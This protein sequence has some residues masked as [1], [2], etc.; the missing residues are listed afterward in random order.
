MTP[1]LS[2]REQAKLDAAEDKRLN[3]LRE[4]EIM[5]YKLGSKLTDVVPRMPKRTNR[6]RAPPKSDLEMGELTRSR[7]KNHYEDPK[8]AHV[9][10]SKTQKHNKKPRHD[11]SVSP[12]S[13]NGDRD[14][15]GYGGNTD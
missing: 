11:D 10:R 3:K 15:T 1:R 7:T 13:S 9:S 6:T 4:D 14:H 8:V 5:N 2:K 12:Y